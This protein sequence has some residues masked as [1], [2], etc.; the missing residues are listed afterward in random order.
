[1]RSGGGPR[2]W[3]VGWSSS[4][5]AA[6]TGHLSARTPGRGYAA[7]KGGRSTRD[8]AL[9]PTRVMPSPG[10][11]SPGSTAVPL[12]ALDAAGLATAVARLAARDADLAGIVARYGP[13][14][15][16]DRAP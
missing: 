16:W 15:L 11:P 6:I 10:R 14:P 7:R 9:T 4:R 3:V 8:R 1:M 12:P 2:P 13:P 5:R